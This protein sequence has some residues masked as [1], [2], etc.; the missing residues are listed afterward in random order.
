MLRHLLAPSAVDSSYWSKSRSYGKKNAESIPNFPN[1][2]GLTAVHGSPTLQG[3]RQ[4]AQIMDP[5]TPEI[6][7]V[8]NPRVRRALALRNRRD[9][10]R[11]QRVLIEG[12]REIS[13]AEAAGLPMFEVFLCEPLAA[14]HATREQAERLRRTGADLVRCSESVFRK[15]AYCEHPDGILAV[16]GQ[17]SASLDGLALSPDPLLL[18]A[19]AVEKPG[20]LGALLRSA[21]A[22]G[23]E[24]VLV[25]D[26]STDIHNPNVIR[27]SLGLVFSLPVVQTDS[28]TARAWL[29]RRG[30]RT[31]AA[32]PH[33]ELDHTRADC[34]GA[35]A[36][37]VGTERDGLSEAWLR[38]ADL[39]VRIPMLGRGDSLN[40][41]VA[42]GILLFEA[43]R[44]RRACGG[45]PGKNRPT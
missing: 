32:T 7:S 5:R 24:A 27:S 36:I 35:L 21:D 1:V 15:L 12:L 44:Q 34:R 6:T 28:D 39:A 18:V 4:E 23:V 17:R 33:A 40:V 43:V 2:A 25:C 20:N 42:A 29:R 13:R 26:R 19:E 14:G 3:R 30:I 41:S 10:D 16:A 22:A 31:L 8:Q 45:E 9:R 37:V 11:E 38:G